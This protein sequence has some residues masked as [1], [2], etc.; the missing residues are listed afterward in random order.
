MVIFNDRENS[1]EVGIGLAV[2]DEESLIK[3]DDDRYAFARMTNVQSVLPDAY[4]DI[5]FFNG[6]DGVPEKIY[7]GRYGESVIIREDSNGG[8]SFLKAY[9][10]KGEILLKENKVNRMGLNVYYCR[11]HN[12]ILD[13]EDITDEVV[14]KL[15]ESLESKKS[16][17]NIGNPSVL[18]ALQ[19]L[20]RKNIS[21][22]ANG[23]IYVNGAHET[24]AIWGTGNKASMAWFGRLLEPR[25]SLK[26]ISADV[27][28][29]M[30]QN[31]LAK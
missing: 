10:S 24:L 3:K 20:P 6:G 8:K 28:E 27:T 19:R 29:K 26:D 4:F 16:D 17:I 11:L 5:D 7:L 25:G 21:Q 12:V 14:S 1:Q 15:I 30:R 31:G 22:G 13:W 18:Y 23:V 9:D 2:I